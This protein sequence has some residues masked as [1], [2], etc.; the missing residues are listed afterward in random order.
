[1]N[2]EADSSYYF[3]FPPNITV[4]LPIPLQ[5]TTQSGQVR[6][7]VVG[8][9]DIRYDLRLAIIVTVHGPPSARVANGLSS[10]IEGKD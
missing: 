2:V 7:A 10:R 9:L 1:M 6:V 8:R 4:L 5:R 3:R